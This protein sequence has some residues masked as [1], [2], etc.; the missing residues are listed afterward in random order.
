MELY[1]LDLKHYIEVKLLRLNKPK[2]ASTQLPLN[3]TYNNIKDLEHIYTDNDETTDD[4]T[5]EQKF[6]EFNLSDS[7]NVG[8]DNMFQFSTS[9]GK[10]ILYETL[11][12]LLII[13]NTSD[14]EL[15]IRD[16]KFR[17]TNEQLD[18]YESMYKK[19]EYSL[20]NSNSLIVIGPKSFH[21]QKIKLNV[22]VMCKYT[23]EA[24]IQYSSFYFN[25][26]YIK[27]STNKIIKTI[28]S[29]YSV[30]LGTSNIIRKYYKKFQ[31]LTNLPFK[32][33]DKFINESLEKCYIEINLTNQSPYNIHINEFILTPDNPNTSFS[34]NVTCLQ[35]FKNFL[36]ESDEEVNL[37]Y[38]ITNYRHFIMN[39][40]MTIN[41]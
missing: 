20:V 21:N 8:I 41:L 24:D 38:I 34:D 2:F 3:G 22:E 26:E 14:K 12:L 32:I 27:H 19:L 30:E 25:E 5:F 13:N 40:Y 4:H 1:E 29:G 28:A 31:F 23:L 15:R 35:E 6:K 16:I 37:V 7:S 33:R 10:V 9:F 17:V 39:V 11:E 18:N 36:M